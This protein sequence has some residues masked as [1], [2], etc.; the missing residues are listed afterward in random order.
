MRGNR[1]RAWR[2]GKFR[3]FIGNLF[4]ILVLLLTAYLIGVT[5]YR[6]HAA[7]L[8]EA[9]TKLF[10]NEMIV[11]GIMLLCAL[12]ARFGFFTRL[13]PTWTKVI[14]WI[15]R[16]AVA[17]ITIAVLEIGADV[18]SQGFTKDAGDADNILV[19]SASPEEGQSAK[20][21][22]SVVNMACGYAQA[23]P[24]AAVIAMGVDPDDT[25]LTEASAMRELLAEKGL[26]EDQ[27][28][29]VE[30]GDD[31]LGDFLSVAE[32][33][34]PARPAAVVCSDYRMSRAIANAERAG[35]SA[36]QR[37]PAPSDPLYY[38]ANVMREI[39]LKAKEALPL[40]K[41]VAAA[42]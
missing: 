17:V 37:L 29:L 4:I 20:E 33:I 18:I 9:Q 2:A 30:K 32:R 39:L 12:D 36:A 15:L 5:L 40:G 25:G 23:H 26:P 13:R 10:R 31:M 34:D 16:I 41:G 8:Q 7:A 38:G 35:F 27:I 19:L 1:R 42:R 21:L 24:D 6:N 22:E 11:C 3:R 14:G 28:V